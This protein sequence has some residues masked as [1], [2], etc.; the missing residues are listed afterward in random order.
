M[1]NLLI[2]C[3]VKDKD[4]VANP[5]VRNRYAALSNITGIIANVLLC[6]A[7]LTVG[8]I[9]GSVALIADALNNLTDAGSNIV[10][11]LGLHLSTAHADKKHP[12]G[13]G[14]LEYITALAVD[15]MIIFVG[16]ELLH[17]AVNKIRNPSVPDMSTGM[18]VFVG[19][20]IVVKLWMYVFYRT[21][22][23]KINSSPILATS[24]DSLSDVAATSL[25]FVSALVSKFYGISVD[26]W[27]GI[28][29]A[30]FII[31]TGVKAIYGTVELL[32]GAAPSPKLVA[33]IEEFVRQYP[34]VLGIHDL[35]VHDYGPS[36]LIV[37]LHAEVSK[38]YSLSQAHDLVDQI[39]KDLQEQFGC[40]VT[41]HPDPVAVDDESVNEMRRLAEECAAEIDPRF[42][43]HDFRMTENGDSV[44]MFFDLSIPLDIK[45]EDEEAAKLVAQRIE[46]RN[47]ACQ[48]VIQAEHPFV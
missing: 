5:T 4:N 36:R 15:V 2:K 42:T 25:V 35:M 45:M 46:E 37:T 44:K 3:F 20:A 32:L 33:D 17:T 28:L 34:Q 39:E 31:F 40:L 13:H 26:G 27:A 18:L 8:L 43:I 30:G 6:A 23:K 7:K 48:A 19:L 1:T 9:S 16:V 41:I 29:V 14:R 47:P 38:D 11:M 10:T 24:L 22:G 21:I 12:H